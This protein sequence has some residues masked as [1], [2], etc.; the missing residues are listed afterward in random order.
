M[1]YRCKSNKLHLSSFKL[2]NSDKFFG[3][4]LKKLLTPV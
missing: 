1:G 2:A 4:F 3:T